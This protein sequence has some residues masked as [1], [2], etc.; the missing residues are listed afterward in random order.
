[1]VMSRD[2]NARRIHNTKIDNNALERVEQFEYL[3][4]VLPNK[5]SMQEE[6]KNRLN[7]RNV[8]HHSVRKLLSSS[9]L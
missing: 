7:S 3:G 5:N 1:M 6:I 8:C 4:T 9:K 2:Q